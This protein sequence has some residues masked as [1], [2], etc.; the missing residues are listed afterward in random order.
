MLTD[1]RSFLPVPN[2][3]NMINPTQT[4]RPLQPVAY[5]FLSPFPRARFK[6]YA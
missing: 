3:P 6:S 4:V 2:F 5:S 1:I